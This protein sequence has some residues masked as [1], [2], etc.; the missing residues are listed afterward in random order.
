MAEGQVLPAAEVGAGF[1]SLGMLAGS[2][3]LGIAL[4]RSY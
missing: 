2:F 3:A 4:N 1:S